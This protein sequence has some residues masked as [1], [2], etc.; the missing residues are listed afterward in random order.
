MDEAGASKSFELEKVT[1]DV[2]ELG[3]RG[4]LKG[5]D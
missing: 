3:I 5:A 4:W 2:K 1:I